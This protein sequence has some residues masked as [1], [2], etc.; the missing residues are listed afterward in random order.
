MHYHVVRIDE[1]GEHVDPALTF[2][3]Q[4]EAE[5]RAVAV[6]REI[7]GPGWSGKRYP[8]R[9]WRR[10]ELAGYIDRRVLERK[11]PRLELSIVRCDGPGR[12]S[13]PRFCASPLRLAL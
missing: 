4:D 11:V 5:E 3:R 7:D 9:S 2:E 8:G 13:V 12:E 6:A 10:Q 1:E